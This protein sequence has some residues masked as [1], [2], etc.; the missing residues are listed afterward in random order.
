[1][2]LGGILTMKVFEPG[3]ATIREKVWGAHAVWVRTQAA[4]DA[5]LQDWRDPEALC[6][7]VD[8]AWTRVLHLVNAVVAVPQIVIQVDLGS[9]IRMRQKR[10]PEEDSLFRPWCSLEGGEPR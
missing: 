6:Q 3:W 5:L 4:V 10:R 8:V 1:V 7:P 2:L 9:D